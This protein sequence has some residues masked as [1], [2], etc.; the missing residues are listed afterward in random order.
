V[1]DTGNRL[2]WAG[3]RDALYWLSLAAAVVLLFIGFSGDWWLGEECSSETG[4]EHSIGIM[5][6]APLLFLVALIE[7]LVAIVC[8]FRAWPRHVA[9]RLGLVAAG[10]M[11]LS[12]AAFVEAVTHAMEFSCD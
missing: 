9:L 11:V 4:Y 2:W 12:F 6:F 1:T 7:V 10:A 8:A 3:L 5:G